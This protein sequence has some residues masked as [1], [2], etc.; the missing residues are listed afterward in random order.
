MFRK[1]I[2]ILQIS[3]FEKFDRGEEI[4]HHLDGSHDLH[5]GDILEWEA[6]G[7][8]RGTAQITSCEKISERMTVVIIKKIC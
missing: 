7:N 1:D 4:P 8:L 5:Q 2:P 3:Q 6:G